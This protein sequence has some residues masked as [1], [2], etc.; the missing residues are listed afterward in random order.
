MFSLIKQMFIALLS[1]TK[2]LATECV[3]LNNEL[4]MIRPFLVNLLRLSLNII[5]L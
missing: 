3:S 4:Y 5:Y 1:C 2:S